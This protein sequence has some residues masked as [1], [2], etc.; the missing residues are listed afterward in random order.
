[1]QGNC[2]TPILPEDIKKAILHSYTLLSG[3]GREAVSVAV[4]SSATAE[5]LPTASFAGQH[6]L[7]LNIEG[8]ET[9][10]FIEQS[11]NIDRRVHFIN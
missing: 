6:D 9:L 1:M 4:R 3:A 10:L 7:F 11:Y 5:D 2:N 8:E